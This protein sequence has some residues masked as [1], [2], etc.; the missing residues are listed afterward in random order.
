MSS[1]IFRTTVSLPGPLHQK[2][3]ERMTE[4]HFSGFS[5]YVQHLVR[6]DVLKHQYP[7]PPRADLSLNERPRKKKPADRN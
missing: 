3:T 2:A 4:L 6:E 7:D 5:D 1:D